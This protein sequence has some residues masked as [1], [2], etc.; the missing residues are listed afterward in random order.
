MHA[1][2]KVRVVWIVVMIV[3]INNFMAGTELFKDSFNGPCIKCNIAGL[4]K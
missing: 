1:T 3:M 2:K 4:F